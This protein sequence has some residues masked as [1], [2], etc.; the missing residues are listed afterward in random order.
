MQL[1]RSGQCTLRT[2][3][4]GTL[5]HHHTFS[6]GSQEVAS[7]EGYSGKVKGSLSGVLELPAVAVSVD[8]KR[9]RPWGPR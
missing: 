7:C 6:R 1:E 4:A 3:C 9:G 2:V 8:S 5:P